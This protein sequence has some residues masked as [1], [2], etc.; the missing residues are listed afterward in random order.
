MEIDFKKEALSV[1]EEFNPA[2]PEAAA[3]ALESLWLRA[4]AS[5]VVGLTSD[6]REAL[7][8][9]GV[10]VDV[11]AEIGQA[12]GSLA[13]KRVED[14][15]PLMQKL[16]EGH[17]REGRIAAVHALG[18]MELAA[19]ATVVPVVYKLARTCLAWEDC[20]QLA[21]RAL[22]PIVRKKPEEWLPV[23]GEWLKDE[24]KWVRRAAVTVV[25]R[26][27]MKH[28][29][30][31]ARCLEL[32]EG[33]LWD[34]DRDVKRAVSFAIRLSARGSISL[35]RD[36]LRRNVPPQDARAA[37]VLCDVIRSMTIK[38]LPEFASL[39]PLYDQW[40]ENPELDSKDR[41]SVDSAVSALK[42]TM[43]V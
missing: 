3:Q 41:R 1:V 13:R 15:L 22:E 24:N 21:M 19:P 29:Q 8:A 26:L 20:D 28:V 34:E 33:L 37:W 7:K 38:F 42:E 16:W 4:P 43:R 18:P 31:T 25:A 9:V 14:F 6:D 11:L 30:L 40:A 39:I 2:N 27:P 36:L 32:A 35:V 10:P 23:M 17:G 12:V 5:E